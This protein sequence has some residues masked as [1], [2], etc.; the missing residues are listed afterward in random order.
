M[1]F[2]TGLFGSDKGSNFQAQGANLVTPEQIAAVQGGAIQ[3]IDTQRELLNALAAQNGIGNQSNVFNQLQAVASGQGPNPAQ[4]MLNQ[5]TAANVANQAALMGGQRGAAANPALIARQAAMQG[6]GTQQQAA[7]QAA[8]MQAQQSLGALGQL[9]GIANA[10]VAQQQGALSNLNS[11][12]QN[13]QGAFMGA[14]LQDIQQQNSANAGIAQ[15]NAK[16]EQDRSNKIIE[17]LGKAAGAAAGMAHGGEVPAKGPRS[18][19][20]KHLAGISI[21]MQ[22]GGN[23]PGHAQVKGD[24]LKNDTVPA[25]LSPGEIVIPRSVLQSKNP[26]AAAAKFVMDE[27][28]K[29]GKK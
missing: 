19:F 27:L 24:S 28:K 25:L 16:G 2:V 3:G 23:V 18:H 13:Q 7:G 9:G 26:G 5:A 1:G 8:A 17:G 11:L 21:N 6:A 20:G 4:A 12:L 22:S 10:Q 29:K 15:V 14:K